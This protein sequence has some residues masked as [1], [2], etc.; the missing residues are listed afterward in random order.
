MFLINLEEKGLQ[1]KKRKKIRVKL[2]LESHFPMYQ[3]DLPTILQDVE[4]MLLNQSAT[5]Q[6]MKS[7]QCLI[8][9]L[10]FILY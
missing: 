9:I 1:A 5:L 7:P 8:L 6:T 2:E 10:Y 4:V 3:M